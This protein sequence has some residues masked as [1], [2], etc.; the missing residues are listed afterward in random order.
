MSKSFS[1]I[2]S[3]ARNDELGACA[4]I[5]VAR[6]A[7]VMHHLSPQKSEGAGNAGATIAPA[8]LRAMKESTQASHHRY[9]ETIRH[10]LRDG[11][12][13][14]TRSPWSAGLVSLRRRRII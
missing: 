5:L 1:V 2:A 6:N 7:R 3:A 12:A 4:C 13:A 9:A 10:S 14:Y 8:A 11:L